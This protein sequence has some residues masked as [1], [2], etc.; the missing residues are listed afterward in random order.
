[1]RVHLHALTRWRI[2]RLFSSGLEPGAYGHLLREVD[3]CPR[4]A[5]LYSRLDSLQSALC[6]PSDGPSPFALDRVQA[7]I[8][9]RVAPPAPR[10]RPSWRWALAPAAACALAI[11]FLLFRPPSPS[12]SGLVVR[13]SGPAQSANVGIRMLRVLP[14][15][16]EESATVS[17]DDLVTFTYTNAAPGMAYLAL[18][19]VQEDG[20]VRWYYPGYEGTASIRVASDRVDEPLGDGIRIRVNHSP[21]WLRVSAVFSA[22]PIARE[23]IEEAVRSL[24]SQPSQLH[25][26]APLPLAGGDLLEHSLRVNVVSP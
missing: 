14:S 26:L 25:D 5:A 24:A 1:M 6:G 2:R 11:A 13:G 9:Q 19:G 21:G 3:G 16:L 20:K 4:C 22:Q 23:R 17:L 7:A 10:A 12:D 15:S 18:F 8:F